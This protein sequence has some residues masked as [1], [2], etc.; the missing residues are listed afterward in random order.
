ME[1]NNYA[2]VHIIISCSNPYISIY[3]NMSQTWQVD[4]LWQRSHN[5]A[6]LYPLTSVPIKCQP[7]ANYG[8]QET[9]R[10]GF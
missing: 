9:A 7:S 8:I 4:T 3:I 1:I 6:H 5:D 10:T 2:K